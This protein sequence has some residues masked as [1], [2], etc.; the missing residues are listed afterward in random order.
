LREGIRRRI[1]DG[2]LRPGTRLPSTREIARVHGVARGT[3]VLA[4]DQLRLEGYLDCTQ[5][6]G[7]FVSRAL[8]D[9]LLHM[10]GRRQECSVELHKEFPLSQYA[11]RVKP[12]S[13]FVEPRSLAFRT[14]LPALDLFPTTLWA[15]VVSRRIRAA[16]ASLLL[17]CT[18]NGYAPLRASIAEH[19]RTARGVVCDPE[20]IVVT[21]GVQEGV[22]LTARLLLNPGETVLAEDPG[23]QGAYAAFA[24]VGAQVIPIGLDA[25]GFRPGPEDLRRS[26]LMYVT[27]AHQFPTG[28]TMSL[29]RRMDLLSWARGVG[30]VIFED[31]YDSDFRYSGRPV[32]AIL[33]LDKH[34]SVILAGSF[35]KSMFPALRLGYLVL[36]PRLVDP[37]TAAKAI[38]TRQHPLLEQ[39]AMHDFLSEGHFGTHVRRM[40]R[41]Y[42]ER[43]QCLVHHVRAS[44]GDALELSTI[45][46][47][48]QTVGYLAR[49]LNGEEVACAAA[50][51]RIDVVPL[52]RYTYSPQ[53]LVQALQVGFAA[54]DEDAIC[55]GVRELAIAVDSVRKHSIGRITGVVH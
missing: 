11:R 8:P 45:E 28:V 44:L 35:N 52:C 2:H 7:T 29:K 32:P 4:V 16:P 18:A 37:F 10:E 33:G 3:A 25:E 15:Q 54:V 30:A 19:L 51:R 40:R 46:A 41:V 38:S 6:S 14:N 12:F 39:A 17:G 49:G 48:L 55:A 23:F 22:E 9:G 50:K 31:D 1:L 26:R 20:Q 36:P 13:Y 34:E 5:G 53:H 42:A 24:A 47:G 21:S 43:L 27:P